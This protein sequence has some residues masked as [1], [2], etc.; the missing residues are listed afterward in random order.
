MSYNYNIGGIGMSNLKGLHMNKVSYDDHCIA[1]CAE[2]PD[3]S[4]FAKNNKE[5]ERNLLEGVELY[6]KTMSEKNIEIKKRE[7]IVFGDGLD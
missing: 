1:N 7:V 4:V 3:V 6:L 2:Y 5:L